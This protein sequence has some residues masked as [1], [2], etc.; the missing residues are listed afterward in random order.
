M[1]RL[2]R[3]AVQRKACLFAWVFLVLV[4]F[5]A[6][7]AP[8][9]AR[10]NPNQQSLVKRLKPPA[11]HAQGLK[12]HLLGTD[13]LGRDV[14][15]RVIWGSRVS[16]AVAL[17][18]VIA[19]GFLGAVFGLLSGYY[20]GIVDSIIMRLVD[21]QSAFPATLLAIALIAIMGPS[22]TNLIVV[23]G[24]TGWVTYARVVRAE[25]LSLRESDFVQAARALGSSDLR[26]IFRHIL[27]NL[28]SSGVVV[29]TMQ[30]ARVIITE[31]SLSFLGLGVP[32]TTPTWGGM[33]SDAQVNL[34]RAPWLATVPGIAI[35]LTVL[36]INLI[37]DLLRDV[38]DPKAVN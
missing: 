25:T 18:S 19:S 13:Q 24:I 16:L 12:E 31:A 7:S 23:L 26:I 29:L 21:I 14:F 33:L 8:W 22:L 35:V 37:G 3:R 36:S 9:I 27:P 1:K 17:T 6:L 15:S 34:G 38:L 30:V 32:L 28:M 5:C 11:W 20:G 4:I 10:Y 2:V